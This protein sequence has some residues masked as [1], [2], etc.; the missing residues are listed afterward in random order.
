M[1]TE[2]LTEEQERVVNTARYAMRLHD[3]G[4]PLQRWLEN[5]LPD[6]KAGFHPTLFWW[7]IERDGKQWKV[8]RGGINSDVAYSTWM[9]DGHAPAPPIMEWRPPPPEPVKPRFNV[10]EPMRVPSQLETLS[11]AYIDKIMREIA[12]PASYFRSPPFEYRHETAAEVREREREATQNLM[13]YRWLLAPITA[14]HPARIV[15]IDIGDRPDSTVIV[16][17]PPRPTRRNQ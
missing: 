14:Q 1:R 3:D 15:G 17:P 6:P 10:P 5:Y 2:A 7:S 11:L 8:Q 12:L 4:K 9:I 16:K 13:Q